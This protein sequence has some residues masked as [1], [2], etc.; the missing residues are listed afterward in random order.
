MI[1]RTSSLLACL[2]PVL[3]VLGCGRAEEPPKPQAPL[4]VK[5]ALSKD[6][7]VTTW[8]RSQPVQQAE[9]D[10]LRADAMG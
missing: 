4:Y 8:L 9:A 3:L 7:Y 2:L 1:T 6:G 5:C 10:A